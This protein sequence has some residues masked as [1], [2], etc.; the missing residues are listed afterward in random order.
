MPSVTSDRAAENV[1]SYGSTTPVGEAAH[2]RDLSPTQ[3]KAGIAAWLGWMF[4]GLDMHLYT[5]AAGPFVAILLNVADRTD[6]QVHQKSAWIQAAFLVGW[7]MG[8]GFFGRVGD[9]FGRSRTLSLTILTY[10]CFT[11]LSFLAQTWWQ[12][13][14]FRFVSALGIGGEWAVGSALLAETWPTRWR[15]WVAAVLQTGVNVGVLIACLVFWLLAG[16]VRCVFL[17]G[18]LPAII[19]YWIRKSVPETEEWL[20][21]QHQRTPNSAGGALS[22]SSAVAKVPIVMDLFRGSIRWITIRAM[23][24]CGCG[25]TAWWGFMF[26]I[27]Q[28]LPNLP[29]LA[30]WTPQRRSGLVALNFGLL[31]T[32]SIPGNFFAGWLAKVL[33]YRRAIFLMLLGFFLTMFGMFW[34]PRDHVS[35][36]FWSSSVGFF[37]G[38]WGL[39]TMFLPPLFPT[40]LRT[41]GAGFTYNIGR[42]SAAFGTVFFGLFAKVGDFRHALLLNSLLFI[43]AML[44][45]LTLPDQKD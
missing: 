42:L 40:L 19:V 36:L 37:S 18:V 12:L 34:H 17:V 38:V 1:L 23:I 29:D 5:L 9:K 10:A 41:T 4:D 14:I 21:A 20:A 39:F 33:G 8:G 26:C 2:L 11:G 22:T 24:V 27:N 6:P 32:I 7:A 13:L 28:H 35:L 45:A 30:S 15:P 25:L 44:V 3:W 31:I 16:H 43:P